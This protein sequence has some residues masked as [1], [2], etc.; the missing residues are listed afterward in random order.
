[1]TSTGPREV[2]PEEER[3][4]VD[5][6]LARTRL[7]R[8]GGSALGVA[9]DAQLD[10]ILLTNVDE[11]VSGTMDSARLDIDGRFL[12]TD[13]TPGRYRIV[14]RGA[15]GGTP[16]A[17]RIYATTEVVVGAED[18]GN[19]VLQFQRGATLAGQVIFRGTSPMRPPC[20][21]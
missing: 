21:M 17:A 14:A 1:M 10:P 11:M 12:F 8:V 6:R 20:M 4:G 15:G 19:L 7:A 3:T 13:V 9:A 2:G 18:I 5:F 16:G